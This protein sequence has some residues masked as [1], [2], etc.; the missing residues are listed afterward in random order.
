MTFARSSADKDPTRK[1]GER[2][3][4]GN[5]FPAMCRDTR[6][7][8]LCIVNYKRDCI[9]WKDEEKRGDVAK[10]RHATKLFARSPSKGRRTAHYIYAAGKD[11]GG[12]G[13]GSGKNFK[14]GING[15]ESLS[16][17]HLPLS[18]FL[19]P[20]L[21]HFPSTREVTECTTLPQRT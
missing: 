5:A 10:R 8:F 1:L 18:L 20:L 6:C 2:T 21:S 9:E 7:T 3:I 15:R 11:I 16:L 19:S 13:E 4:P 12:G 17:R 14:L